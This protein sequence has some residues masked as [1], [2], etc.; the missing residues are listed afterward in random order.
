MSARIARPYVRDEEQ[1]AHDVE[2]LLD[3]AEEQGHPR[4]ITDPVVLDR[5]AAIVFAS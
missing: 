3:L 4:V 2:Y 5:V 1:L